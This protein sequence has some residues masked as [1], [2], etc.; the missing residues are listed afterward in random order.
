MGLVDKQA[1]PGVS[2]PEKRPGSNQPSASDSPIELCI[3]AGDEAAIKEFNLQGV[4][5]DRTENGLACYI[6]KS[7]KP[8]NP[9]PTK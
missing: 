8:D 2:I 6:L 7:L 3:T 4:V 9:G 1:T 5:P